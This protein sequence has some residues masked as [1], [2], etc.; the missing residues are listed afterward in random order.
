MA[1]FT[2]ALQ[3]SNP[4]NVSSLDQDFSKWGSRVDE[5]SLWIKAKCRNKKK[6]KLQKC[7]TKTNLQ[8]FLF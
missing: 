7:K 6:T 5:K 8:Y 2:C 1:N 3:L 4:D